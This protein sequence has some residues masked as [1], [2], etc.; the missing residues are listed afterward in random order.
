MIERVPGRNGVIDFS[1]QIYG[2]KKFDNRKLIFKI[3]APYELYSNRKTLERDLKRRIVMGEIGPILDTHEKGFHWVGKCKSI[4]VDDDAKFNKLVATVEFDVYPFLYHNK[5][6]FD[7]V[8]DTFN[9]DNDVAN[10][11]KYQVEGSRKITLINNGDSTVS[12]EIIVEATETTTGTGPTTTTTTTPAV[13]YTVVHGDYLWKIANKYGISVAQLKQ[14]N[15]LTS[16]WI[17][18]GDKLIVKPAKTTTT[19]TGGEVVTNSAM[20]VIYDGMEFNLQNGSNYNTG[21]NLYPGENSLLVKGTGTIA[22]HYR[23]EV[24]A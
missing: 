7:D 1:T 9:F 2:E 10:Y 3:L 24:M 6:Y 21:L 23:V 11:T 12:P 20:T 18:T 14:W 15:N 5:L 16:N 19:T 17:Y 13:I 4:K 22:F 8:W